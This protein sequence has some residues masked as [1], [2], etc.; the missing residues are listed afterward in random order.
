MPLFAG[1]MILGIQQS[2][3]PAHAVENQTFTIKYSGDKIQG[4]SVWTNGHGGYWYSWGY[5]PEHNTSD[6]FWIEKV[7]TANNGDVTYRLYA[8]ERCHGKGSDHVNPSGSSPWQAT[9][10]IKINGGTFNIG[11]NGKWWD[12]DIAGNGCWKNGG[13][14]T[15]KTTLKAGQ[16]YNISVYVKS[17]DGETASQWS[18]N[19][20]I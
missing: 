11:P 16:T 19:L 18:G 20:K 7:S 9:Y 1:M 12:R 10:Q 4:E 14:N 8:G 13:G 5:D 2:Y 3:F 15:F 17:T 6:Y